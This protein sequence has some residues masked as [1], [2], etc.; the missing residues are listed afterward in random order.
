M[1]EKKSIPILILIT[2]NNF[3]MNTRN[4]ITNSS[5]PN[6]SSQ[7]K[8]PSKSFHLVKPIYLMNLI[9][10]MKIRDVNKI[11][12]QYGHI[13]KIMK[14]STQSTSAMVIF[15]TTQQAKLAL[16]YLNGQMLTIYKIEGSSQIKTST[17]LRVKHVSLRF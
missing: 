14:T 17:C 4:A 16:T 15:S 12:K 13:E 6:S 7:P 2:K 1:Q 3:I 11:C 9:P 8:Q 10:G 5:I